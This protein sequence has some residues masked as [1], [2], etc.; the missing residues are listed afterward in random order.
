MANT[1]AIPAGESVDDARMRELTSAEELLGDPEPWEAWE[2]KLVMYSIGI[3][4][5]GLVVLG[6]LVNTFILT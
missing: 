2:S 3:A 1:N 4:I 6:I 5:V